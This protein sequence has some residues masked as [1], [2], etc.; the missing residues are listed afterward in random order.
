MN[1][2]NIPTL[3]DTDNTFLWGSLGVLNFLAHF[4]LLLSTVSLAGIHF[5]LVSL[6][7][8]DGP[9]GSVGWRVLIWS[10]LFSFI[11]WKNAM[12]PC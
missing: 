10:V 6:L 1:V 2:S 11:L 8:K 12:F 4:V 9:K 7:F 5:K 3:R